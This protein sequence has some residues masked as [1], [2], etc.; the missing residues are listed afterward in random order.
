MTPAPG[1]APVKPTQ[2]QRPGSHSPWKGASAGK[3]QQVAKVPATGTKPSGRPA[4]WHVSLI[5]VT[6]RTQ[7]WPWNSRPAQPSPGEPDGLV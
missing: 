1:P 5:L 2:V 7:V 6:S 4:C 3:S